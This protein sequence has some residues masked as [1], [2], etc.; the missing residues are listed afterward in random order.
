M[1][2]PVIIA[3]GILIILLI[4]GMW[5]YLLLYGTPQEAREVF[6]NLGITSEQGR[7]VRVVEVQSDTANTTKLALNGD[8]QQ[9]TTRAVAG[10][11][12]SSS[13]PNLIRYVERGTG[14]VYEIDT[15][16]GTEEQ[17]SVVTLPQANEAVFS[18]N[19]TAVAITAYEGYVKKVSVGVLGK[20]A[21]GIKMTLL[22]TNAEN[23]AF[24]DNATLNFTVEKDGTT[25]GYTYNITSG[26]QTELFKVGFGSV[27]MLS[28]ADIS[29]NYIQTKP[30]AT[31][32]GY[33]YTV[34]KGSL[35][36][37]P[38]TGKGLTTFMNDTH[39]VATYIE[40][41]HYRSF[42]TADA[43]T[44]QQPIPMFEEKCTFAPTGL[45]CAAPLEPVAST[46][47]EDWYKGVASSIDYIWFIPKG[48]QSATLKADLQKISGRNIDV[49]GLTLNSKG[50]TLLFANK[51]DQSLWLYKIEK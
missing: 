6:T 39:T 24:E 27:K 26:R 4:V 47:L 38:Q 51:N 46:Y 50:S 28:G 20:D 10:F 31:A 35:I 15:T 12:F 44:Q 42:I 36:A 22:P 23:I 48:S 30:A 25:Y 5:V 14:H 41:E 19:A 13:T 21:A 29:K 33:L 3:I 17:I 7:E 11:A 32:E 2:R 40:N 16:K 9:L 34:S 49:T 18:P 45:W 1:K 37:L 43:T 8:L